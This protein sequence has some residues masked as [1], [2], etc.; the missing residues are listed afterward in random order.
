M[1]IEKQNAQLNSKLNAGSFDFIMVPIV[2]NNKS[3]C[4]KLKFMF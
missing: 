2:V 4:L 1:R 3:W